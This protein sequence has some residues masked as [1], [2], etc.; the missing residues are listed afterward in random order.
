[1]FYKFII[2]KY[3][4]IPNVMFNGKVIA[5]AIGIYKPGLALGA[6]KRMAAGTAMYDALAANTA[7]INLFATSCVT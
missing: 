5:K 4:G 7:N 1:M 6:A 3:N 2:Y